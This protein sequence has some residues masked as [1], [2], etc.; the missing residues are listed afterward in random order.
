MPKAEEIEALAK[1]RG[2]FW[3]AAE[4]YGGFAGFYDY[5]PL[6]AAMKRKLEAAWRRHFLALEENFHEIETTNIMPEAAFAASGHLKHFVDPTVK[7]RRCGTLHRADHILEE[8][9]GKPFEGLTPSELAKLIRKHDIKC[10]SC[11]GELVDFGLLHLMFPVAIGAAGEI[12]GFLRPETAQGAYTNFLRA[13]GAMRKKLPLGLAI[14]GRAYR[15]EISPRQL[16]IRAREFS[17]AELQIFFDSARL[18]EHPRFEQ[19]KN[20]RL[21]LWTVADRARA[22]AELPA[23]TAVTELKLPKLYV[24]WMAR[25]QQWLLSEL[26]IPPERLRFREVP[27]EERIF[28]N[29]IQFDI[30]VLLDSYGWKELAAIHYRTDHDLS[31]HA[32]VSG[33]SQS[34]F[35]EGRHIVP[36][37]LELT[38]GLDRMIWTLLDLG[39]TRNKRLLLRIPANLAPYQLAVFPIV[40]RDGLDKRAREVYEM[41]CKDFDTLYD[42]ADSIGRRY[43][44]ADEIGVP[45]AITLDYDT[46]KDQSVTIRDRDTTA[47]IRIKIADLAPTL[48][49]L[50]S[51]ELKFREAGKLIISK[52]K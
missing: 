48:R 11:K 45:F 22:T 52:T 20:Y 50:L 31:G 35:W 49:K 1:R 28:Y 27:P 41:L 44:R 10:S 17:Q 15:N 16:L 14:I 43:A 9:L 6:G 4:I 18:D 37:V 7:C 23:M 40:R 24:Y 13:F 3:P 34:V 8:Y 33:R 39:Y 26:A 38:F 36:H 2:F 47:Q 25:I 29:K 30:E 51:K 5:G 12:R 21:R 42:E 19:I 46:L 32:K